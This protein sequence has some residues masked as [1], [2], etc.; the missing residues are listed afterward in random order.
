MLNNPD[1]KAIFA[2]RGRFLCPG[3]PIKWTQ[4]SKTLEA[5][6]EGGADVFYTVWLLSSM[7]DAGDSW[8]NENRATLPTPL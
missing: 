3:E 5:V 2:P 7:Q 8:G 1:W 4:Y 6:A